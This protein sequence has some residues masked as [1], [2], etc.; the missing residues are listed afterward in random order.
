MGSGPL[1][2]EA[3]STIGRGRGAWRRRSRGS[4]HL[5]G[6]GGCGDVAAALAEDPDQPTA[7]SFDCGRVGVGQELL[8]ADAA[9]EGEIAAVLPLQCGRFH[10]DGI[11]LNRL[12]NVDPGRDQV[13]NHGEDGTVAVEDGLCA[14]RMA[15]DRLGQ[16]AVEWLEELAIHPARDQQ[17]GLAPQ[18]VGEKDEIHPLARS[19]EGAREPLL[20]E[21]RDVVQGS[22]HHAR[23]EDQVHHRLLQPGQPAVDLEGVAAGHHD[24]P[25]AIRVRGRDLSREALVVVGGGVRPGMGVHGGGIGGGRKRKVAEFVVGARAVL[26]PPGANAPDV[27]RRRGA[28]SGRQ[29]DDVVGGAAESRPVHAPGG[30]VLPQ[31]GRHLRRRAEPPGKGHRLGRAV[32]EGGKNPLAGRGHATD[33]RAPRP[34]PRRRG[35]G[36]ERTP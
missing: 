25:L 2:P 34:G 7:L 21:A 27:L 23:A 3:A 29:A 13:G 8:H 19:R 30:V 36:R 20:E 32:P 24:C 22:L 26:G 16:A 1:S 33:W 4:P 35:C 12:Q 18:V 9:L 15:M 11:G 6:V 14:G 17:A 31:D 10:A 5:D 28:S